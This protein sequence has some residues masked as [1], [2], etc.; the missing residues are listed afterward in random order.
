M[1]FF[2]EE[3]TYSLRTNEQKSCIRKRLE[4]RSNVAI[5]VT[6]C[7]RVHSEHLYMQSSR[8]FDM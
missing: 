2:L 1:E 8:H 5:F 7:I 6:Y 3:I 4:S